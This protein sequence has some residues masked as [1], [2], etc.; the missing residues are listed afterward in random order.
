MLCGTPLEE[1]KKGH[2]LL[3]VADILGLADAL[4]RPTAVIKKRMY[5]GGACL[6]KPRFC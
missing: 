6:G 2:V 1:Y 5:S 4:A 3:P